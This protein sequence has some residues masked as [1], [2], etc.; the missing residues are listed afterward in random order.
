MNSNIYIMLN[1]PRGVVTTTSDERGRM[2]V[3]HCLPRLKQR[4]F[5]V[6]RLDKDTTGLLLF[7]NDGE[8]A[9]RLMHPRYRVDKVY[10][11]KLKGSLSPVVKLKI[12]K[13][14]YLRGRKTAPVSIRIIKRTRQ[15]SILAVKLHEGRKR[16]V[17]RIF[18]K[19]GYPVTDL[20]RVRVGNL[21]LG[22]LKRGQ[23]RYLRKEEVE[24]LKCLVT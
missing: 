4:V 8:L 19:M 18:Y 22:G 7:T 21:G 10:R 20:E 15:F 16:Q 13:G 17:R 2:T 24:K 14:I 5:P 11:A 12:E 9:N 6:G 1:K 23:S 3:M